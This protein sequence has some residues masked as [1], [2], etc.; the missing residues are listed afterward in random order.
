[1]DVRVGL[2]RRLSAKELMLLNCGVEEDSWESLG[3]QGDP[4]SPFWRS[5]LGFLWREWCWSWNYSTLAT[6]CKELTHWKRLWWWEALEAGGEGDDRGWDGWMVSLTRWM[7]DLDCEEGW[8]PKNWCFWTVVLEKTLE[9][10]LD[11]KEIQQVHSKGDQPWVFFG[12]ND[13]KAE[14]PVLWPPYVKSWLIGKDSD[15]GRDWGQEEKGTTEDEMA[16]WHHQL[17]GS[18]FG[19]APG[20]GDGQGGLACCNSWDHKE[21]DTTER[22]N[23]TEKQKVAL[24]WSNPVIYKNIHVIKCWCFHISWN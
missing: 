15:A 10:P 1:M 6:S 22:L 2:W 11:C 18:E 23:W 5:A 20:V 21:S 4:T 14:T 17:Y 16:G 12:R 3:L 13:A 8:A 9:S 24:D 7:W 19:W